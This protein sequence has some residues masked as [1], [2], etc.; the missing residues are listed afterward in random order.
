MQ[1][2]LIT[3]VGSR[4]GLS[5][6][7]HL[8]SELPSSFSTPI[9]CLVE[10]HPGLMHELQA[11]HL[12]VRWAERGARIEKGHVYVSKPNESLVCIADGT[13]GIAPHGPHSSALNPVDSFLE[14]AARTHGSRVLTLVL[15]G[16]DHD[17]VEGCGRVKRSGG[18]VLVLDRA[19]AH[20]WG[21]AEPIVQASAAHRVVT[22]VEVAE[23]LRGCFTSQDLLRCAQVQLQLGEVLEAAMRVSGTSMGHVTR[24][25]PESDRLRIVVQRGLGV[26]FFEHCEA[27]PADC[28]AAWYRA[29]R[30]KH[31]VVIPDVTCEPDHPAHRLP[32]LFYRAEFAV[33]LLLARERAEALGAITTLFPEAHAPRGRESSYLDRFAAEAAGLVAQVP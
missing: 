2:D 24:R 4:R 16:F 25:V 10:S 3:V 1:Y 13:F 8:L 27:M 20:Y 28:E 33:P 14:S 7:R 19:T 31:S 22:I 5:A 32:R 9:A 23:A 29:V 26:D 15:S 12:K 21:M 17:G 6:L 30:S 11:S 18:T